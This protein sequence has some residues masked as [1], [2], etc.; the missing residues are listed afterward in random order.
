MKNNSISFGTK[1]IN[2]YNIIKSRALKAVN[3]MKTEVA[4][5]L[6]KNSKEKKK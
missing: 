2:C 6:L 4:K 3:G 1:N 5:S